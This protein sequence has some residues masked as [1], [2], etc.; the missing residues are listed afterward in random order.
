MCCSISPAASISVTQTPSP[1][2]VSLL[3]DI[4]G[5]CSE[6]EQQRFMYDRCM[7]HYHFLLFI[8]SGAVLALTCALMLLN[9]DLHGQV[10][11]VHD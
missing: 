7:C 9:T 6:T 3:L 10:R 8:S 4:F 11:H 5:L 2:Q 1:L